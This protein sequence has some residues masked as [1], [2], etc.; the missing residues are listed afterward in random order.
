MGLALLNLKPNDEESGIIGNCPAIC[1]VL[2]IVR[3]VAKSDLTVLVTGETGTGKELV[4]RLIHQKSNRSGK[5][6][7]VVNCGAIPQG[8]AE[9]VLFGHEK[10]AF[11]GAIQKKVGKVEMA[12]GGTLF[13]DE[14][15]ELPVENQV[16]LL[17]F[18]NDSTFERV[19]GKDQMQV[20]VRIVA[21]T[22]RNLLQG[23][24]DKNFREDLFY[25]LNVIPIILPPL[26]S[27]GH[28]IIT[29]A[30]AFLKRSAAKAGKEIKGL[31]D[32]AE[33]VLLMHDWL[34]N[35]RELK[36]CIDRA[37]ALEEGQWIGPEN[38]GLEV[39]DTATVMIN[40][41][42]STFSREQIVAALKKAEGN[43]SQAAENLGSCRMTVYR[44]IKKYGLQ[45]FLKSLR[46]I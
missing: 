10:G 44:H 3:K 35:V 8:L 12:D 23:I 21:A 9:S 15:G 38:F 26:R 25:R 2:H 32:N 40:A 30:A 16:K 19:G 43:Q 28:D 27:R 1:D 6:F 46:S 13:L 4:A 39:I 14:I 42:G 22:N 41:N 7:V 20:D 11:T 45:G 17:R 37:V 34:G 24:R 33:R 5:P 18:L 31:T 36:S 29:L